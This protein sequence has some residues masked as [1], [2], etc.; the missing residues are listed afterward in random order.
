MSF[1]IFWDSSSPQ[2]L[3]G[4]VAR[5]ISG[6]LELPVE[7]VENPVILRGFDGT[8][9]QYNASRILTDMQDIY[10]RQYGIGD[11]ILI[12]T[13]EDL[14]IPGRDFVF[15]LARPNIRTSIVSTARLRNGYYGRREDDYD[16]IDRLIK[17]GTH[18]IAHTLGLDH[19]EDIECIMFCPNTLDE[20]DRK[21]KTLCPVCREK[22][23]RALEELS[24]E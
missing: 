17:E 10:T 13:G 8:R 12:V 15:G 24:D 21:R 16:A 6:I 3:Q 19:C 11:H 22:L 4:P 9:N 5:G 23:T 1:L 7:V 14:Y 18:E 2:G 20:L